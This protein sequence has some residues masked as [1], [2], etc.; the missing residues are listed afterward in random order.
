MSDTDLIALLGAIGGIGG[1][2]VGIFATVAEWRSADSAKETIRQGARQQRD[3]LI[4]EVNVMANRVAVTAERV[5]Q[6]ADH[7]KVFYAQASIS[8]G[9]G[10]DNSGV[11]QIKTKT[12]EQRN[13]AK[14][15]MDYA[16]GPLFSELGKESDE[17][18]AGKL[19]QMDERWLRFFGQGC[20][21][22]SAGAI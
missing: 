9:Q 8:R 12:D 5:A 22:K 16:T 3:T 6:L 4:R 11:Q 19:R 15:I 21:W 10:A 18:L 20:K 2:L 1:A 17:A 7:L 13:R 14:Q